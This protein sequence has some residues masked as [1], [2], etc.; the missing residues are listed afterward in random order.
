MAR[1]S[2]ADEE[3]SSR[4]SGKGLGIEPSHRLAENWFDAIELFTEPTQT[5][6]NAAPGM[7][8]L[9]FVLAKF[10]MSG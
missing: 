5:S 3:P 4:S 6:R 9:A 8:G 7:M 1:R 10:D 2:P